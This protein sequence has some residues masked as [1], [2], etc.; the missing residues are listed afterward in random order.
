MRFPGGFLLHTGLP[1]PG[2][3]AVLRQEAGRWAR[4]AL[5]VIVHLLAAVPDE[6]ARM[7]ARLEGVEGVMG[8]EIGLPPLA[9]AADALALVQA[10]LGEL[11]VIASLPPGRLA[12]L[13]PLLREAGVAAVS[14]APERGALPGPDGRLVRGRLYGPGLLPAALAAVETA[15]RL[16][17]PVIGGGGVYSQAD[18]GWRC[19][20]PGR[21]PSRSTRLSGAAGKTDRDLR[22][23]SSQMVTGPSLAIST[24]MSAPNSPVWVGTPCSPSSWAKR[25]TSGR[26]RS[27]G[28]ASVKEGRRPLRVSAYSVN[29]ETTIASPPDVQQRAVHLA[30]LV[31]EDAQVG[32]LLGQEAGL[33]LAILRADPQQDDQPWPISAT[34]RPSTVTFPCCTRWMTMRMNTS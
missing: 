9:A 28:A 34:V 22:P 15:V 19:R 24:S 4:S 30:L 1:N 17:L 13:G 25:S 18:A 6:V 29:C 14:L 20:L 32:D 5:P 31:L 23:R 10:A 27:G 8:L 3:R 33:L 16:G 11:P 21:W 7:A 26:A 2:L 12:E